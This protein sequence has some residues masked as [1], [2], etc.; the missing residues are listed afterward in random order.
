MLCLV[1]NARRDLDPGSLPAPDFD[2]DVFALNGALTQR[3]PANPAG[4]RSSH[5]VSPA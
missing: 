5:T 3:S 2:E 4:D 1:E